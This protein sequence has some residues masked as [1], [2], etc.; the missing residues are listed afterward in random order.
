MMQFHTLGMYLQD[1]YKVLPRLTLNLGLR[2]EFYT[3]PRDRAGRDSAL[4]NLTDQA[5][6]PGPALTNPSKNN[7]SPRIGFAYD[8]FGNGKTSLRGNASLLYDIANMG[9]IW[10]TNPTSLPPSFQF[11]VVNPGSDIIT[12][13]GPIPST[14]SFEGATIETNA[15]DVNQPYIMSFNLSVEQQLPSNMMLSLA[16]AGSRGVHLWQVRELNPRQP[17]TTPDANGNGE[18]T[19]KTTSPASP[20]LI[21]FWGSMQISDTTSSSWYNAL[22]VNLRKRVS[23]GLEF[24]SAYT[25]SRA[26]DDNQG[27]KGTDAFGVFN[28]GSAANLAN[29]PF[30]VG[31][32]WAPANFDVKHN[33]RFNATYR[34][35]EIPSDAFVAKIFKGWWVGNIVAWQSGYPISPQILGDRAVNGTS[36]WAQRADLV[37]EETVAQVRA[38][39]I[40]NIAGITEDKLAIPYNPDTVVTGNPGQ[41][42]DARMFTIAPRGQVGNAG[43][44][45]LRGPTL[46]SVDMSLNKD[47]RLPFLG[48]AGNLQFR[49]EIFNIFNHTNFGIPNQAVFSAPTGGNANRPVVAPLTDAGQILYTARKNREMQFSIRVAF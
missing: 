25:W 9:T 49:A 22:Q 28:S 8:V 6:T 17:L 27:Q 31:A 18:Y 37:T 41:W 21:P 4:R 19:W 15:Y 40:A 14:V 11:T 5:P 32:E 42:F 16:Y 7:F 33:W 47:T 48:E 30:N 36:R 3:T 24:Q 13:P 44:N 29:N 43:R 2:Y 1:D 35:P 46:S 38:N 12:L 20:R 34:I 23:H 45:I 10:V 39:Q 26:L